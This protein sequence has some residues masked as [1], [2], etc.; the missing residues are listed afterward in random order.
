ML[1]CAFVLFCGGEGGGGGG[2][3]GAGA[4]G[5]SGKFGFGLGGSLME[6]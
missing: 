2:V 3:G 5:G 6:D 1:D 4:V